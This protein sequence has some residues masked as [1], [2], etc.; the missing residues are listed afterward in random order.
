MLY[1][2]I[3]EGYFNIYLKML[4]FALAVTKKNKDKSSD[5]LYILFSCL[6]QNSYNTLTHSHTYIEKEV[7]T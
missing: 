7:G 1:V 3:E 4:L 5:F 2:T 6:S